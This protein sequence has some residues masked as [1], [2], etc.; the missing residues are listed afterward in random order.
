MIDQLRSGQT[1]NDKTWWADA[2]SPCS[3]TLFEQRKRR[4]CNCDLK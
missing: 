3:D 4:V 1:G 2:T